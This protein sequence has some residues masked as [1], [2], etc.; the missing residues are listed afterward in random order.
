MKESRKGS[1]ARAEKVISRLKKEYPGATCT[2]DFKTPHQLLVATI[3]SAQCTDERVN[4]V[5]RDLFKKY[6]SPQDYA[7]A[8]IVELER[9]IKPTGFF[10]N[11]G[12]SIKESAR[13][14]INKFHGDMPES[15][16][17]LTKLP[18]V[19]RKTASVILCAASGKAE[20]IVVD[21]HVSRIAKRLGF[22]Q[23]KDAFKIEKDLMRII[24]EK[25]WIVF[26]HM[27]I[28]HGR[29]VCKAR[30]PDCENCTIAEFCPSAGL[31]S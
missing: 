22:T 17:E 14:I 3:L 30:R 8:D 26:S 1:E 27:L 15:L 25:D 10:R 21:T 6:K 19:G 7:R 31:F 29:K 5:T 16:K 13:M 20:G 28:E 24:P 2:L 12:R 4:I 11:K 23:D 9:D 18:G